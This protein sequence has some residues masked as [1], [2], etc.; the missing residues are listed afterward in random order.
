MAYLLREFVDLG[1]GISQL[2]LLLIE[3]DFD[4]FQVSGAFLAALPHFVH[5]LLQFL[6]S[7]RQKKQQ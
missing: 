2:L 1:D 7:E 3:K 5:L 6:Q 4:G